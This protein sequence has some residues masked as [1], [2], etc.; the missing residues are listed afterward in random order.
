M[1]A[2]TRTP[3]NKRNGGVRYHTTERTGAMPPTFQVMVASNAMPPLRIEQWREIG[4]VA[5]L[6]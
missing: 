2:C 5:D 6:R 3:S 1:V 4:G